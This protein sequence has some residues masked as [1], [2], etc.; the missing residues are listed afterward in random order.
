MSI[1]GT[2]EITPKDGLVPMV[3]H[4]TPQR[5]INYS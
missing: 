1:A 3:D 4:S 2:K 5:T